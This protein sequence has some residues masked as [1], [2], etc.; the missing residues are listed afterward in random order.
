LHSN[1]IANRALPPFYPPATPAKPPKPTRRGLFGAGAALLAGGAVLASTGR[2]ATTSADAGLL[3][4]YQNL[5]LAEADRLRLD[6]IV[7]GPKSD[8]FDIGKDVAFATAMDDMLDRWHDAA[9]LIHHTSARTSAG[10]RAKAHAT[11][12]VLTNLVCN[13]S[14]ETIA[15]LKEAGE[16]QTRLLCPWPATCW[17]GGV[18]SNPQTRSPP[19]APEDCSAIIGRLREIANA[20]ADAMLTDGP[21]SPDREL[22]DTCAEAL[23]L[24]RAAADFYAQRPDCAAGPVSET[25][26]QRG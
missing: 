26:L 13:H 6:G 9:D 25:V 20:S 4:A 21:V 8:P 5:L 3:A 2:P 12:I 22:L 1:S 18:M 15:N 14:G 17:R 16:Y 23:A 10:L 19:P 7:S 24:F 11:E